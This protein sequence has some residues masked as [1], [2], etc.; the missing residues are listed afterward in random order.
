MKRILS[1]KI[2][3]II[4]LVLLFGIL[5][6]G[7]FYL[8]IYASFK[9]KGNRVQNISYDDKYIEKGAKLRVLN[10]DVSDQIKIK[11]NIRK[12]KVGKY[13]VDYSYNYLFF[14]VKKRRI[15]NIYDKKLPNI[16][17]NGNLESIICP[18]ENYIEEGYI[19][20]DEYDKDLTDKV[21]VNVDE[22][23]NI[24]YSVSDSSKNLFKITRKITKKDD[25]APEVSLIGSN[26]IYLKLGLGYE[27]QSVNMTDNCT[28]NLKL[29]TDSNLDINKEG[30]YSITYTVEDESGNKTSVT[31]DVIVYNETGEGVVYLTFDDGPWGTSTAM[32]LDIL[33]REG[34]KAT[35]FVTSNGSNDQIRREY[36][37]GHKIALHTSTHEYSYIYSSIDNY[38]EDLHTV[39]NRVYSI[40][41]ER[42]NIIR[43]PGGSNNTVSNRYYSGIMDI[44][45]KEVV[46]RGYNY[47]DWNVSAEDAGRCY[48]SDCV[49][50]WVIGGLSKSKANVV[51]MHDTKMHTANALESIIHYCKSN[52][53]TFSVL[54]DTTP[55]V[56]FK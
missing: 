51:L 34:V 3:L 6:F 27:D 33:K 12:N 18:N 29:T 24:I 40:T 31:R 20:Y 15:V 30:N 56:R 54:S 47:F 35:F 8:I 19:A 50:N 32:I 44:L 2:G 22:A 41:G 17:L 48:D 4:L 36:D 14:T 52:G 53:Y 28:K 42:P 45:T 37:E 11:N 23:G 13:T 25:K 55:K 26:K 1:S 43:F 5:F 38:F 16:K 46:N 9:I 7:S 21:I 49:Y 39:E 10:F